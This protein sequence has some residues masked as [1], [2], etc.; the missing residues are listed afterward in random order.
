MHIMYEFTVYMQCCADVCIA[1]QQSVE[2]EER[3]YWSAVASFLSW[4]RKDTFKL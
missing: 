1:L 3:L 4:V 2:L